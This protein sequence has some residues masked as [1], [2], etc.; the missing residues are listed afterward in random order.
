MRFVLA[1]LFLIG[2]FQAGAHSE[3][4]YQG[5]D[6]RCSKAL[7]EPYVWT[8]VT[9]RPFESYLK[10]LKVMNQALEKSRS[11]IPRFRIRKGLSILS[12]GEGYSDFIST[13]KKA[14]P[15]GQFYA[16]DALVLGEDS[17]PYYLT[18]KFQ[19]LDL[20]DGQGQRLQFDEIV[21]S[22]AIN[23]VFNRS[24]VE[25]SVQ[26]MEEI[27]KHLKVGGVLRLW[28]RG[29]EE[30]WLRIIPEMQRRG[31]QFDYFV[32]FDARA[33]SGILTCSCRIFRKR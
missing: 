29:A 11:S 6:F 17:E 12:L 21:S 23:F 27:F 4:P 25:E 28:P 9:D 32:D 10:N 26:T 19:R 13:L 3:D 2:F 31:L 8:I 22:Y 18:Q 1:G 7:V 24:P 5:A 30:R 33:S 15:Q 14:D 20:R 16:V